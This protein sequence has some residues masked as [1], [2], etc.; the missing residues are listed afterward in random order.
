MIQFKDL[1][2]D[3]GKDLAGE[4]DEDR[5]RVGQIGIGERLGAQHDN[6]GDGDQ[7]INEDAVAALEIHGDLG[8][9]VRVG[10]FADVAGR[11]L[12][13]DDV[14]GQQETIGDIDL[15]PV[16]AAHGREEARSVKMP[17][18]GELVHVDHARIEHPGDGDEGERDHRQQG[19]HR[20][21]G[22]ADAD[23]AIGR[24]EEQQ[25]ADHRYDQRR[26]GDEGVDRR[27]SG[28]GVEAE[29]IRQIGGGEDHVERRDRE[30][31]KPI[32]P[33]RE[34]VD[35]LGELWPAGTKGRI[36]VA[37]RAAGA[38]RH[39]GGKLGQKEAEQPAGQRDEDCDRDRRG[40]E[41]SHHDRR[42]A[43]H[44]NRAGEP[45]NEGAPPSRLAL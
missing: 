34:A 5:L 23:A 31:A 42:D 16:E 27:E 30:P 18:S 38:L 35:V 20:C 36:G 25:D 1:A 21:E 33:G 17:E 44:Q 10:A 39:H 15:D 41:G 13:G 32:G 3:A 40:A 8:V 24:N 29:A 7:R 19:Q 22:R 45:D 11:R 14:P 12:H 37:G 28:R 2:G 26:P 9:V 4:S 6:E 43:G